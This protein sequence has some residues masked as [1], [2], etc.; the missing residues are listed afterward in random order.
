VAVD[1]GLRALQHRVDLE[2]GD[3]EDVEGLGV[4]GRAAGATGGCIVLVSSAS[5]CQR[6]QCRQIHAVSV[7]SDPAPGAPSRDRS[8]SACGTTCTHWRPVLM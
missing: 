8:A 3:Q 6:A 4:V 1:Q 2:L 7:R 5:L